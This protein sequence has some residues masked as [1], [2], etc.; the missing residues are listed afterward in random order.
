MRHAGRGVNKSLL[1]IASVALA[2]SVQPA[3]AQPVPVPEPELDPQ[4]APA[5]VLIQIS[6]DAPPARKS[7][8]AGAL[9]AQFAALDIALE[10]DV[11][12]QAPTSAA[13]RF[14]RG[15]ALASQRDARAVFW[16][17]L[18]GETL[19]FV[20]MMDPIDE[21]IL[22]R[23]V[24]A[25]APGA[26]VEALAVITKA[27]TQ[28]LLAGNLASLQAEEL[29]PPAPAV[30][31]PPPEP[32]AAPP[33][34]APPAAPPAVAP[35]AAPP[36][37]AAA[38]ERGGLRLAVGYAGCTFAD[39]HTWQNGLGLNA[40]WVTNRGLYAGLGY[41][42][43]EASEPDDPVDIRVLRHPVSAQVGQRLWKGR[44]AVDLEAGLVVDILTRSTAGTPDGVEAKPDS[45][46]VTVALAPKLRTELGLI[47]PLAAYLDLG[48]GYI[49]NNF[50]YI[51]A[52]PARVVLT[53]HR[54]RAE[55]GAGLALRL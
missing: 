50:E 21:R 24:D 55:L 36:P 47:G 46:R 44:L 31:A 26:A 11:G 6:G 25:A 51:A 43:Y 13:E 30:L 10:I 7:S 12:A 52:D 49:I 34:V 3:Q 19:W 40:S 42:F 45:T 38:P 35:P 28:A 32:P 29:P 9:E 5:K 15:R 54:L 37:P 2:I 48:L 4:Q 17:E 20:Y 23:Q 53:P 27:S 22:V 1:L 16:I 33:A 39:E 18:D 8:L 14:E 41:T